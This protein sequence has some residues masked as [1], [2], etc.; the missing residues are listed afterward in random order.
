MPRCGQ[1][2]APATCRW[3]PAGTAWQPAPAGPAHAGSSSGPC[4][5]PAHAEA[6]S[7]VDTID[8]R[9]VAGGDL[10]GAQR[11]CFVKKGLE[12]DLAIAQH[13]GVGR[14]TR[15]VFGQEMLEHAVPV[16]RREIARVERDAEPA[17]HGDGILAVDVA[18]AGALTVVFL[19]VLHEQAFD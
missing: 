14:A 9:V 15:A 17:A 12:L 4:W 2:R 18:G 5:H 13:I 6:V 7:A 10:F 16:F 19:P 8:A 3:N 1:A 11:T